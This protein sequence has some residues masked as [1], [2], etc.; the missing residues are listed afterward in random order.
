[1]PRREI[2]TGQEDRLTVRDSL[3]MK[4]PENEIVSGASTADQTRA[5]LVITFFY[6]DYYG[7][8]RNCAGS[9]TCVL[10][11]YTAGRELHPAPKVRY[12]TGQDYNFVKQ[13]SQ[14]NPG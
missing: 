4:K 8:P 14:I 2:P 6:P 5:G 13:Q 12:S 3:P 11:G 7:R 1:M 9:C 10:A